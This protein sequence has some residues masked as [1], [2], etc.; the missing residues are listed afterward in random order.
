[1]ITG[2]L[3]GFRGLPGAIGYAASKAGVMV[4]AESLYAD[5]RG[6]GIKVQ[7]AN[8]GFIRTRLTDKND[9][10]MPAMMEPEEAAAH[11]LQVDGK[12]PLQGQLSRRRFRGCSAC[13]SSF[14]I[15][16][17]IGC[18]RRNK[19]LATASCPCAMRPQIGRGGTIG[20]LR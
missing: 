16:S 17:I 6:I 10:K 8:P 15:G 1:M 18:L 2:S 11:M 12:R 19:S 3:S 5:L 20:F 7:V 4:L 14:R 9:F 13:R